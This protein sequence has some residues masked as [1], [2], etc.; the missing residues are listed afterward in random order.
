MKSIQKFVLSALL[1]VLSVSAFADAPGKNGSRTIAAANT[2][3]NQYDVLAAAAAAGDTSVTV[4]NIANLS[5]SEATGGGA[6]AAGDVVMLY[7]PRGASIV[8]T[9]TPTY[10]D[11]SSYGNAG[12]YELRTVRSV[13]GNVIGLDGASTGAACVAGLKNSYSAGA[14]VIRVPQYSSLTVSAGA[15]VVAS[16]W[17][18]TTGGVVTALV[19]GALTVNGS[20]NVNGQG[21]RGGVRDGTDRASNGSST[22]T[23]VSDDNPAGGAKGEGIASGAGGTVGGVTMLYSNP[24]GNFDIGA[25]AN[26]GGGGGSH[27]GGGGGGGNAASAL[28]P[29]CSTG[30]ATY[31][32]AATTSF[33]WCGQGVMPAGVT[34]ATAWQFDPGYKANGN[35]RTSFVGGGRGGYT[36][37]ANNLDATTAAG[38]PAMTG[39]GGDNRRSLGGWG[40][41]PLQ[42]TLSS[43]LFFGGGGG[44]GANNNDKGGA[45]G[46]GGGI[47]LIEAG[48]LAGSGSLTANGADGTLATDGSNFG[49]DAPGGGGA[50]G[51]I[52]VRAGSGSVGSMLA[53]GGLGGNQ[54]INVNEA[55]GPGGG[56]G[57]GLIALTG[58][59]AGTQAANAGTGG[60]TNSP[61]L[62]EFP[63]NGATDGSA[64]LTGQTAP[65]IRSTAASCTSLSVAKDN[66]VTSLVAGSTTTYTLTVVNSG[67][68]LAGGTT[69]RDPA[70]TGLNCTSVTCSSVAGGAVC[71]AAGSTTIALLQGASGITVPTLPAN[72]TATFTLNCSVT[73]TGQ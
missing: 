10:G 60:T 27:N 36:Y 58:A 26:G 28:T 69:V 44:A 45:G 30:T 11:I 42:Q 25:P 65:S 12:N 14:Q 31:T 71:P 43:R 2:V 6:L 51:T 13:A 59:T 67:P 73:A 33:I 22:V 3:I 23:F 50:G 29:Y 18:G 24:G 8:T 39:W 4:S 5:S 41:R 48:S 20:I 54:N 47:I 37:S 53:N 56:G 57:G 61:A 15:S 68:S 63:R 52:V 40:G 70:V 17:G 66:G 62:T 9:N 46:A 16:A 49:N 38:A 1:F 35:A 72:S 7:Q 32:T 21:F 55:E 19:Q 64:G 34:G